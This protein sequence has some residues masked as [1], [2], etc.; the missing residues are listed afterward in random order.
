MLDHPTPTPRHLEG[1]H[2]DALGR[3][4]GA[5]ATEWRLI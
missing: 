5:D 4:A 3:K 1:G 2:A